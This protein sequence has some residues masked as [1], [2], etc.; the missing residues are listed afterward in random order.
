MKALYF[1]VIV[2]LLS[3]PVSAQDQKTSFD[4]LTVVTV[5]GG[6]LAAQLTWTKGYED[7]AY[8]IVERS[9]DGIDF[10][11]CAIVFLSEEPDFVEYKFRDKILTNTHG[12]LYRIGIVSNQKRVSYLP[13]KTLIAP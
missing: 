6:T 4:G 9:T 11:Q 8:F 3:F 13:T 12:L 2:S 5:A 1:Y 10:K 7:V